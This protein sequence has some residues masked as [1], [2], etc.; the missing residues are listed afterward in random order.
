MVSSSSQY[1]HRLHVA[2]DWN[3]F[4]RD[5]FVRHGLVDEVLPFTSDRPDPYGVSRNGAT[6]Y[7]YFF[8]VKGHDHV[9]GKRFR[10]FVHDLFHV[11]LMPGSR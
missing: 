9:F 2:P 5:R 3:S 11:G 1:R 10:S 6:R 7:D 8:G 4:H